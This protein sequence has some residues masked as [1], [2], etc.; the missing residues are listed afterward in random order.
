MILNRREDSTDRLLELAES[1]KGQKGTV[2]KEDLAWRDVPVGDRLKHSL[3]KG[4]DKFIEQDAEEA[5]QMADRC[6]AVIEGPLMRGMTVVGD[7]FGE[8][9]MFLRKS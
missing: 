6:L 1:F 7:L 5:R 2:S 8:G 3:I 4:I 9:K